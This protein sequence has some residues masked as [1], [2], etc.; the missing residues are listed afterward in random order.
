[1]TADRKLLRGPNVVPD[2][3][4][5]K[6]LVAEAMQQECRFND[7]LHVAVGLVRAIPI[8][9]RQ[10]HPPTSSSGLEPAIPVPEPSKPPSHVITGLVPVISIV[11]GAALVRIGM[12]GTRPA[13]TWE[14]DGR[15]R[16]GNVMFS[17]CS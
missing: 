9:I 12:A 6:R 17:L 4:E 8:P 3:D 1:M 10:S 7:F 16:A 5:L 11:G 2:R 13:M 14:G 15:G